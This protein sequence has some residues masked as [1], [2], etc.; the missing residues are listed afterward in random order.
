M[1]RGS[2]IPAQSIQGAKAHGGVRV[3]LASSSTLFCSWMT[4][5]GQWGWGLTAEALPSCP[6]LQGQGR[7]SHNDGEHRVPVI[8]LLQHDPDSKDVCRCHHHGT[9]EAQEEGTSQLPF[10]PSPLLPFAGVSAW[11]YY[12]PFLLFIL[13]KPTG[14]CRSKLSFLRLQLKAKQVF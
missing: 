1:Y 11:I 8:H 7:S 14:F 2:W 5:W 4:L 12:K 6:P 13:Q 9:S 3:P 10:P